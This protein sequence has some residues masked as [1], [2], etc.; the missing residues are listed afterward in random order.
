MGFRIG[1]RPNACQRGRNAIV[2]PSVDPEEVQYPV[3]EARTAAV[4]WSRRRRLK[5]ST[6]MGDLLSH[7]IRGVLPMGLRG[8][9]LCTDAIGIVGVKSQPC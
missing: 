9:I 4:G 1:S 7:S 2:R 3:S 8:H 6:I 5:K